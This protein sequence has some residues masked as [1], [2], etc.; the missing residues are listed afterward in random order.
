MGH[1][2]WYFVRPAPGELRPLV[3]A[4]VDRFLSGESALPNDEGLVRY[5]EVASE[6]KG[7]VGHGE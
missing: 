4:Q 5:I 1:A 6:K 2:P 3:R 7:Q